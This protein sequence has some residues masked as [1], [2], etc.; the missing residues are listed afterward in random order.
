MTAK[1]LTSWVG[2]VVAAG[3]LIATLGHA[4]PGETG[5]IIVAI[6]AA[7]SA[8]GDSILGKSSG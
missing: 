8:F 7:L 4:I 3:A 6:A 1:G 2:I 5:T